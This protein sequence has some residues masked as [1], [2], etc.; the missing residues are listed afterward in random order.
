MNNN[1]Y[2]KTFGH[3]LL[4]IGIVAVLAFT[5]LLIFFA[6][7]SNDIAGLYIF[8]SL[9]DILGSV[10]AILSAILATILVFSA[11]KRWIWLN[12]IGAILSWTG[13][14]I[15]TLDSLMAGDIIPKNTAVILRTQY[16]FP[17]LLT[18]HDLHFGFGLIGVWLIILNFQ[19]LQAKSWPTHLLG[20][21]FASGIFMA[22][23]LFN[24]PAALGFVFLYPIWCIVTGRYILKTQKRATTDG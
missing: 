10:E 1:F 11:S 15:A 3:F 24:S 20:L 22:I 6:G 8:G 5:S 21:G 19:A 9:N 13:A 4:S 14:F 7:Y 18:T 16:G 17:P 12:G 23:G 2:S